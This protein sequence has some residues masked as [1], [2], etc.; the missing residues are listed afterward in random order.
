[1]EKQQKKTTRQEQ[2]GI[3]LADSIIEVA[4]QTYNASRGKAIIEAC[5]KRLQERMPEIQPK[6]ATLQYKKARYG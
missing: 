1:M 5:I 6:K 3:M 4:H 2:L